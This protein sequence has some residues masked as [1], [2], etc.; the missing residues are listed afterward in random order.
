DAGEGAHPEKR[1][2]RGGHRPGAAVRGPADRGDGQAPDH[3]RAADRRVGQQGGARPPARE[4]AGS[5]V[6]PHPNPPPLAG[7]GVRGGDGY[8]AAW[9][10]GA[11]AWA[12]SCSMTSQLVERVKPFSS[13][14]TTGPVEMNR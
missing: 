3:R 10:C 7:E 2:G 4:G 11:S 14:N 8:P 1:G 13:K 9:A 12:G 6:S 5:A